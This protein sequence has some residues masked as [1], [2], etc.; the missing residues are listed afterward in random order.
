MLAA[1]DCSERELQQLRQKPQ[2]VI[3]ADSKQS[4]KKLA[5][6]N[7]HF[8]WDVVQKLVG[9]Y[10][11]FRQY[12]WLR[13]AEICDHLCD[14]TTNDKPTVRPGEWPAASMLGDLG[15]QLGPHE[16]HQ[17]ARAEVVAKHKLRQWEARAD[18]VTNTC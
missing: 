10:S 5:A 8:A 7:V 13:I 14:V 12:N 11:T 3:T 6:K 16:H 9:N 2:L 1:A 17:E 15:G 18:A 4:Q